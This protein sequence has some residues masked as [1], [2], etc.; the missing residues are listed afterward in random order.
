LLVVYEWVS[1]NPPGGGVTQ[2]SVM[3]LKRKPLEMT[4]IT[5]LLAMIFLVLLYFTGFFHWL[6]EALAEFGEWLI[7]AISVLAICLGLYFFGLD[8]IQLALV[9]LTAVFSFCVAVFF[10]FW[11]FV[12]AEWELFLS[13]ITTMAVIWLVKFYFFEKKE[14]S[15]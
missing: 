14:H 3:L 2:S 4:I 8:L 6:S 11:T 15:E 5:V 12:V 9:I 13:F 7:K 1:R 10:G